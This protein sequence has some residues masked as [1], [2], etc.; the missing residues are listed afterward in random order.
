MNNKI[1]IRDLIESQEKSKEMFDAM[2]TPY[3]GSGYS[4]SASGIS[5]A[6]GYSS[7]LW[8]ESNADDS[9]EVLF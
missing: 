7:N 1:K 6:S 3:C 5:C 2:V 9:N 8:C 4:E